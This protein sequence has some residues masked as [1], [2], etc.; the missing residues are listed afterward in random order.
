MGMTFKRAWILFT[1]MERVAMHN[2]EVTVH[3]MKME[4]GINSNRRK[5]Q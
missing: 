3:S 2:N 5:Q 4:I 1:V